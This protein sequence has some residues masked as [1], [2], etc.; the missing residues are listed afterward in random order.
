MALLKAMMV[1]RILAHGQRFD[2]TTALLEVHLLDFK[3]DLYGQTLRVEFVE[4]IRDARKFAS[5]EA[6][7]AAIKNDVA[8]ARGILAV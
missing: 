3:G 2:A 4:K 1:W 5:L 6:L 8:I 7:Q